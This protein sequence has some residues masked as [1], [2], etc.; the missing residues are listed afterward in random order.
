MIL[1][2][3]GPSGSGKTLLL[4]AL[5]REL[6]ARG[7]KVAAL[8]HAAHGFALD[9]PGK[10][11]CRLLD[12]G[13]APVA[14]V[15]PEVVALWDRSAADS[16]DLA[17][18]WLDHAGPELILVEGFK[19]SPYP[20]IEIVPDGHSLLGPEH[21]VL[22]RLAPLASP[23]EAA[24]AAQGLVGAI[25]ARLLGG[26]GRCEVSILVQG[27][28]LPLGNFVTR[29]VAGMVLGL[30]HSLK[31]GEGAT[32]VQVIVRDRQ[33]AAGARSERSDSAGGG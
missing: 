17:A 18:A 27:R 1:G 11:S 2:I 19:G 7:W 12:A 25:G 9:V 21:E 6:S 3:V 28:P 33:G 8:K 13:A 15:G 16:L 24:S 23:A 20:K 22:A 26:Q 29:A 10:D 4:E 32:D 5:A 30:V 31:G 14:V